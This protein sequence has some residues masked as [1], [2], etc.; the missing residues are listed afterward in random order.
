MHSGRSRPHHSS[1]TL[2]LHEGINC[3]VFDADGDITPGHGRGYYYD[4]IRYLSCWQMRVDGREMQPLGARVVEPNQA[5][6]FSTNPKLEGVT[7]ETLGIV[8]TR[9]LDG[10]AREEIAITNFGDDAASFE[11]S[12]DFDAD[13]RDVSEVENIFETGTAKRGAPDDI[14]RE[15][16]EGRGLLFDLRRPGLE[17]ATRISFDHEPNI[18]GNECRFD[19]TIAAGETYRLYLEISPL[20]IVLDESGARRCVEESKL[21]PEVLRRRRENEALIVSKTARLETDHPVL[22]TAYAHAIRDLASLSMTNIDGMGEDARTIAAGIPWYTALFGRDSLTTARL[23]LLADPELA[24][25]TLR[26]LAHLQGSQCN[27][28][29]RERPGKI[30]HAYRRNLAQGE[31]KRS[32]RYETLD[33]TPLFLLTACEHARHQGDLSL[34]QSLW[35]NLERAVEWIERFG[36]FD[37]DGLL[38]H[39]STSGGGWKDSRDAVRHRDG[40]IAK[41]PIA[42]V[43]LQGYGVRALSLF[44]ELCLRLGHDDWAERAIIRAERMKEAIV[45]RYW[46]QERG[47]FAEALDGDKRQVDSLTSNV[48]HLLWCRAIPQEYADKVARVFGTEEFFSG[49]GIR[50]LASS[51]GGY[52][53]ISYHNGSV[54]PHD[55]AIVASGLAAY[56]H[57][58]GA[59]RVIE[60]LLSA[61]E[62]FELLRPPEVF[63]GYPAEP[64]HLPVAYFGA[65]PLQAWASAGMVE[66]V[67]TLLGLDVNALSRRLSVRPFALEGMSFLA[68]EGVHV[69]G[70]RIDIEAR[71]EKRGARVFV[72][73]LSR[74]WQLEG[75]ERSP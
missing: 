33:A 57:T 6:C 3:L 23:T 51:E 27:D 14:R 59:K 55:N 44:A 4:D 18:I 1:S 58:E 2:I 26:I 74:E 37:G 43:E 8:R 22:A 20:V 71:F 63:A 13:F 42:L 72:R 40:L 65:N 47:F 53:P 48:G 46:M 41:P 45:T 9:I 70:Q 60:A 73:G 29:K 36:D 31:S 7:R 75:A 64:W 52:N 5:V 67:R 39:D 56:G 49:F 54:W 24:H 34:V 30:L 21:D 66:I 69:G 32:A 61:I 35:P 10:G 28:S 11:L 62:H 38:E 50:T 16:L 15:A 12:F 17:I 19:L 68:W 25:G